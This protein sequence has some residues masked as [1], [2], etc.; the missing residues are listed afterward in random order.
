[1]STPLSVILKTSSRQMLGALGGILRKGAEHASATGVDE[2]VFLSARLY[3]DMFPLTRQ[4]Q[5]ACDQAARGSARLAGVALPSFPD[6]ETSF[7][8][9]IDRAAA[10]NAFCQNQPSAAIDE[11]AEAS[12]TIPVGGGAEMTL[13]CRELLLNYILPNLY[14]HS[15]TAYGLLRHNGVH[16]GKGDFL[17]PPG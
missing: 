4:V 17:R 7:A 14:F 13:T 3:P 9:L 8:A 16:L 10:A 2:G 11:R 6:T 1:M 15:A 12:V 5:I